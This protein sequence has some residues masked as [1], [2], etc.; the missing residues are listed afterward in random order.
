MVLIIIV[1]YYQQH[2][3]II[4][5]QLDFSQQISNLFTQ[6]PIS[7]YSHIIFFIPPLQLHIT[8]T[9]FTFVEYL[10][11]R[12]TFLHSQFKDYRKV[13]NQQ[14]KCMHVY[15]SF[16][17]YIWNMNVEN[18]TKKCPNLL[19]TKIGTA[20]LFLKTIKLIYSQNFLKIK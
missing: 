9:S 2:C 5:I 19:F 1:F 8:P 3:F 6:E 11:Y 10:L 4:V 16:K 12:T 18:S 20:L 15:I 7:L 14:R 13:F 17:N